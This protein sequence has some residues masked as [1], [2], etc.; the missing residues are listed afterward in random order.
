MILV[1]DIGGSNTRLALAEKRG[2]TVVLSHRQQYANADAGS[3]AE[4]IHRYRA[5]IPAPGRACLAVAGPTDGK[6]VS[7]TNLDWRI[8]T[9]DLEREFGL[10][11]RLINDFESVAWGLDAI[12]AADRVTLQPGVTKPGAARLALGPGTGLGVALSVPSGPGHRPLPGEG[13]HIGF[14]ATD[15]EQASL[16][17]FLQ[18]RHGRVSVER[19]LSGPGI[20]DLFAFCRTASGRPVKRE[21]SPAEV[22]QG[23]LDGSEPIAAWAMRLFCRIL[24]QTAGDL[25]LVAGAR[26]GVYLAG[27]I[28]PRILPL[29]EGGEF[30]AGFRN[31]G[32][33]SD[34]MDSV[35]VAVVTDPDIG[36][37]GAALAAA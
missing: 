1:G 31:K 35:P 30:M 23:A 26:G 21:R 17:R 9:E 12:T 5:D 29:L 20:A 15:E 24:G 37:K 25:A 4:L 6:S 16:L 18:A 36:L 10:P 8:A 14:A 11:V 27:G 19:I 2:D 22:T 34:W 32:R 3:L 13:G 28:P 33:F 7:L